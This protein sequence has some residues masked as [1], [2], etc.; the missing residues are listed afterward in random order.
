M[1]WRRKTFVTIGFSPKPQPHE[2]LWLDRHGER[3][4]RQIQQRFKQLLMKLGLTE[5]IEGN[6]LTSYSLRHTYCVRK[7]K[8][9]IPV[10]SVA[11]NMGTSVERIE[12]SYGLILNAT[13]M[14]KVNKEILG[15]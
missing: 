5:D 9:G 3:E 15:R 11:S 8:Q 6:R 7:L 14:K 4:T 2:Y 13:A 12:K 1:V 10:Y